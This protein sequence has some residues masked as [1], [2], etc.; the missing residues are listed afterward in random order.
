M[1]EKKNVLELCSV[2]EQ[3]DAVIFDMDGLIFDTERLF[4][5][6]LA[7]VMKEHGYEL[8]RETY[9]ATLGMGGTTLKDTMCSFFGTDYPFEQISKEADKR[10]G[11][12]AD[13]VGLCVKPYI[14]ELLLF[15]QEK[16]IPCAVASSTKG[17]TVERYLK[18]NGL[19]SFFQVIV[20]GEQ[21]E[22][23]K[24]EPD[25]F[26]KACQKL[27]KAPDS[28]IVLED[29]ENGVRAAHSAGCEVICIPDLKQPS[30][31]VL[32]LIDYLC[33]R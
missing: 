3:K 5:E 24:P 30:K 12:I 32:P 17:E 25:I 22:H 18:E 2:F 29:S 14:R 9:C 31:E 13:T 16:Q 19:A 15:L 28:C 7:V 11:I 27:L 4:M 1:V 33:P 20:G 21:V 6:Q 23:S 8:D 10:T 26:Q